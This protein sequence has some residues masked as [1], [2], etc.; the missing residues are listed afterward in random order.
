MRPKLRANQ[1][2]CRRSR[3][4]MVGPSSLVSTTPPGTKPFRRGTIRQLQDLELPCPTMHPLSGP[5]LVALVVLAL[6]R[7][8]Q[9]RPTGRHRQR[10]ARRWDC[11]PI[12]SSCGRMGGAELALGLDGT[13]GGGNARLPW[14]SSGRL[15]AVYSAFAVFVIV[16]L[17]RGL[18][19]QS[20][21]CFGRVD[22]P[23]SVAHIAVNLVAAT[24]AAG[25]GLHRRTGRSPPSS[26]TTR[27]RAL[28]CWR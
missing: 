28:P 11:R 23:P 20:C 8:P 16:A 19:I 22:T 26:S 4:S 10:H 13:A 27:L 24:T 9:D 15:V 17:R 21:G 5:F 12:G 3:S 7:T 18:S 14:R 6:G 2:K 1:A 25:L